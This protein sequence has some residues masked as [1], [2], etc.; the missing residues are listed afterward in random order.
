MSDG[1]RTGLNNHE[2]GGVSLRDNWAAGPPTGYGFRMTRAW[3]R[4]WFSA[5]A[6]REGG[7]VRRRIDYVEQYASLA[8]IKREAE[9]RGWHVL[10]VGEQVVVLCHEG[11]L[12]VVC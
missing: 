3:V 12:Q 8:E 11:A 1:R 10:V 4:Q 9:A 5:R 6:A 7:M 2:N